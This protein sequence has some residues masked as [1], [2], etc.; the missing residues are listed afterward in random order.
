MN[1]HPPLP[2]AL[3]AFISRMPKVELHLHL[4]GSIAPRTL[5]ELAERNGV[6]IPA[7]DEQGVAQLFDYRNFHEFLTVF[8]ALARALVYPRDFEQVAYE[9]GTYL[10]QQNVRYAEVMVSPGLYI[11]RGMSLDDVVQG[12]AAGLVRARR[13]YGVRTALAFDFGR[14][15]GV[16]LAWQVLEIAVRNMPH[17]VVAWSIGGDELRHPPEPFAEVFAAARRAGLRV[18]AH[19]GEV[20]GPPSVWGAVNTLECER[21]GHGIRSVEDPALL[22]HLRERRVM[23]DVCP[24]SNVRTGAAPGLEAHPLRQLF[25]A[26]VRISI[27]S[28]DPVFFSTT[29]CDE[30]RL[31]ARAFGFSAGE[32]AAVMLDSVEATFLPED[33][34]RTL[35]SAF[36]DEIAAL[37][38][39]LNV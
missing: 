7:R 13:D 21:L 19:A 16:E 22:A 9:L 23:L 25:D 1:T 37:R 36:A 39:M 15:F 20:V 12:T 28:D 38:A 8:M 33:E 6:D 3:D 26:G 27:N 10:A 4:E 18:M 32:L 2:P 35:T 14:Q 5:L 34:K 31:A 24:T 29:L 30:L 11:K 17:G